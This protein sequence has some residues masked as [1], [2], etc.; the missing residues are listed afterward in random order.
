MHSYKVVRNVLASMRTTL[1]YW[2]LRKTSKLFWLNWRQVCRIGITV[3]LVINLTALG[4][5]N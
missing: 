5:L 4:E 2:G 3:T 1:E